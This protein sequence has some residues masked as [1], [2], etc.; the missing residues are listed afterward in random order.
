MSTPLSGAIM[1]TFTPTVEMTTSETVRS[2]F[3][4]WHFCHFVHS[5]LWYNKQPVAWVQCIVFH[6]NR[7]KPCFLMPST[8]CGFFFVLKWKVCGNCKQGPSIFRQWDVF[9]I[10]LKHPGDRNPLW[11]LRDCLQ[12]GLDCTVGLVQVVVDN[13]E[14]KVVA[15][16]CLDFRALVARPVQ[17]F[18]LGQKKPRLALI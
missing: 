2:Y 16:G 9:S 14:V 6:F 11:I 12:G 4:S 1:R 8:W 5:R 3:P 13:G 18:I 7:S 10:S 17:F 15:I